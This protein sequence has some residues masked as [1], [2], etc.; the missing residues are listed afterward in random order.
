MPGWPGPL[1]SVAWKVTCTR[2][3]GGRPSA[4]ER[5]S[6]RWT[7]GGRWAR[8]ASCSGGPTGP[9]SSSAR[10]RS[11]SADKVGAGPRGQDGRRGGGQGQR[12]EG[13]EEAV[14]HGMILGAMRASTGPWRS[15]RGSR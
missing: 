9:G 1:K 10:R 11:N 14:R 3:T 13:D 8:S 4:P 7:G 15:R 5:R 2:F 12:D 6:Q